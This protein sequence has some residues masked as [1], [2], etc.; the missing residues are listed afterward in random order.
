MKNATLQA[1][2]P[3]T[4]TVTTIQP[5]TT[6]PIVAA[7]QARAVTTMLTARRRATERR[8]IGGPRQTD[9]RR[10]H[11]RLPVMRRARASHIWATTWNTMV[12]TKRM[13]ASSISELVSS[14]LY[15]SGKFS[16]SVAETVVPFAN[17]EC[18]MAKKLP[19]ITI[20]TA[21]VSPKARP[22]PRNTAPAMPDSA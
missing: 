5:I 10:A 16:A 14:L 12:M 8:A 6:M 2:T 21:I 18:G 20:E 7:T 22:R 3:R 15:A 11:A 4:T 19:P 9:G 1:P 17:R 13:S